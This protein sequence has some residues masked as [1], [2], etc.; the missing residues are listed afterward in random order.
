MNHYSGYS[1][2]EQP[3]PFHNEKSDVAGE[4]VTEVAIKRAQIL[5]DWDT[6]GFDYVTQRYGSI[7][8]ATL[9]RW[10]KVL[11]DAGG[12]I[13][14][15]NPKIQRQESSKPLSELVDKWMPESEYKSTVL[16]SESGK[17]YTVIDTDYLKEKIKIE[18]HYND[19]RIS[20]EKI[21]RALFEKHK[22]DIVL[23]TK[24]AQ[25]KDF[26]PRPLF[27][28]PASA[29]AAVDPMVIA[30][31]TFILPL[32]ELDETAVMRSR[33]ST[34]PTKEG[35]EFSAF[36]TRVALQLFHP[37]YGDGRRDNRD[38]K[39]YVKNRE[40]DPTNSSSKKRLPFSRDILRQYGIWD[41]IQSSTATRQNRDYRSMYEG[42]MKECP[43]LLAN[44]SLQEEDFRQFTI[45]RQGEV[46]NDFEKVVGNSGYVMLRGVNQYVGRRFAGCEVTSFG[47][48]K[49]IIF[50][51]QDDR[52]V[53]RAIFNIVDKSN[54]SEIYVS[55]NGTEVPRANADKTN[56]Q[57]INYHNLIPKGAKN[58]AEQLLAI[59]KLHQIESTIAERVGQ[60]LALARQSDVLINELT[61]TTESEKI[62]QSTKVSSLLLEQA[63]RAIMTAVQANDLPALG[64]KLDSFEV[65]A[66][67]FVALMQSSGVEK[68]VNN[69]LDV[70][71]AKDLT[72][73]QRQTMRN[74]L[75]DNYET[76]YP[77]EE[78]AEF[79]KLVLE[80]LETAFKRDATNF[81]VLKDGDT[82]VSFNRFDT[83]IDEESDHKVLYFGSF[84]ADPRY[85][86][87]G[88]MMLEHTIQEKMQECDAMM[89]H[90]D[91]ESDIS[92]KYIEDG[93]IATQT[94]TVAGK[95]SF[96]IWRTK[97]SG[98]KLATKQMSEAELVAMAGETVPVDTDY[99]V[100][101]V[102]PNDQFLEL[103]SGLAF[104]LT[105]YFTVG[106]KTYAAFEL[107]VELSQA[108]VP[109]VEK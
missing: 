61:K 74:L 73:A 103:D 19:S 7:D 92:K 33:Q 9:F 54:A 35:T 48:N 84:N 42:F 43:T 17:T 106:G 95:F 53:L 14:A 18:R 50:D 97:D 59:Q 72:E 65:T 13:S 108:F 41:V 34:Y 52:K 60:L 57:E 90:C 76:T 79:R 39:L 88:G 12:K 83:I 29:E 101:E 15:L 22:F 75:R 49:A 23:T 5:N 87:V 44:G 109:P 107:N 80:S 2:V 104:L 89:A 66:R 93:F 28:Y 82:I 32:W 55:K 98:Q 96:E 71:F 20:R 4:Q 70:V 63:E 24:Q 67:A 99:F 105:R 30:D 27:Y 62:K 1:F 77:G 25:A 47:E 21:G 31:E 69:P 86:G 40:Y 91:P 81:Y 16:D 68:I 85:R 78:N 38:G 10:Q 37:A 45:S 46:L 36:E 100:R 58:E 11:R 26:N 64:K 94:E 56:L 51:A 3:D 6:H 8:R 102:E